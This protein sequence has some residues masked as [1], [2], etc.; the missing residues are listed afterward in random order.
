ML[1]FNEYEYQTELYYYGVAGVII[2]IVGFY[3]D[4]NEIPSLVKLLMQIFVFYI[5]I[6]EKIF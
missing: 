1:Y 4:L 3:D 6:L 2:S 5:I